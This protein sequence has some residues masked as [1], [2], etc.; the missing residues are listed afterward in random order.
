MIA[1]AHLIDIAALSEKTLQ[2]ILQLANTFLQ[3]PAHFA[4]CANTTAATLFFENST[5]TRISFQLAAQRLNL[6]C[7]DLNSEYASIQKG[8]SLEDTVMSLIAMGVKIVILRHP[9]NDAAYHLQQALGNRVAVINAGTGTK[10]HPTQALL[11]MLTIMQHKPCFSSLRVAIMG[12]ILHSRVARSQVCALHQLGVQD[13]RL[14]A[15]TMLLPTD[16]ATW[17]VTTYSNR[18]AGL[19]DADVVICLRIQKERMPTDLF[20]DIAAYRNA[21]GLT[22]AALQQIR[23]DAI[24]MHPGPI[25]RNVEIDSCVADGPQSVILEQVR[26]GVALRAAVLAA[27]AQ[28][29]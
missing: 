11:D 8:E 29:R 27:V 25:N 5:R 15:P 26:N 12:D 9:E 6:P 21:F 17:P 18:E 3:R 7:V 28:N 16:V 2:G 23:P 22:A 20:P 4:N 10:A 1:L 24:V 14:I 13:I 19:C